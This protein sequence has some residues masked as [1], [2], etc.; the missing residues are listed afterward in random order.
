M[1]HFLQ[2]MYSWLSWSC[3]KKNY[4]PQGSATGV[5]AISM[6]LLRLILVF[7]GTFGPFPPLFPGFC[8]SWGNDFFNLRLL[9]GKYLFQWLQNIYFFH[10]YS[11]YLD[12][13]VRKGILKYRLA[14]K[15]LCHCGTAEYGAR[16]SEETKLVSTVP[17][18]V[19]VPR[20]CQ[21]WWMEG[22]KTVY[23]GVKWK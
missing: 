22:R 7:W 4:A 11:V 18:W 12:K 1:K 15:K 14:I 6:D 10:V 19:C 8:F 9:I 23:T 5:T 13:Y 21:A 2:K 17:A 20:Q 3:T 16:Q